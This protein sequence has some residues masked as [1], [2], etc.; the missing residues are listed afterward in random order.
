MSIISFTETSTLP[1][2][3]FNKINTAKR[4]INTVSVIMYLI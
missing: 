2:L 1:N 3:I 4:M